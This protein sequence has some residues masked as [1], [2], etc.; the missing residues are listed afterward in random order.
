LL[1]RS[2]HTDIAL[3]GKALAAIFPQAAPS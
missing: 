3:L 1:S 2:G